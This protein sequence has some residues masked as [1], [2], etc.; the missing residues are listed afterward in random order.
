MVPEKYQE[1]K[2]IVKKLFSHVWFY[3]GKY[4]RKLNTIQY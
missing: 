1:N 4:E 2:K 3:Y